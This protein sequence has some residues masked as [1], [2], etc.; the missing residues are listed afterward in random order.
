MR[1]QRALF[2]S[3][4]TNTP[5]REIARTTDPETSHAAAKHAEYRSGSHK[6]V[7]LEAYRAAY[8]RPLTDREAAERTGLDPWQ[9]SKRCS[10][11]RRDG[12]IE[13]VDEVVGPSGERV[14][15]CAWVVIEGAA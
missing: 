12:R 5:A 4:V 8:P 3:G 9:V 6:A 13:P 1:G 14:R 15:R 11:L 2:D 10:D 7:L